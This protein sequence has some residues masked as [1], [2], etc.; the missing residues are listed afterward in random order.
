LRARLD[1]RRRGQSWIERRFEHD[2]ETSLRSI[3][4][5]NMLDPIL[6]RH[7]LRI[8]RIGA[9]TT[10]PLRDLPGMDELCSATMQANTAGMC[11]R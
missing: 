3:E 1:A 6:R 4:V 9:D 11:A 7:A 10:W 2:T 5:L 8:L